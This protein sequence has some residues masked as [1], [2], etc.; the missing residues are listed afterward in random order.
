[1]RLYDLEVRVRELTDALSLSVDAETGEIAEG[2]IAELEAALKERD[3]RVLDIACYYRE[4]M[5][6]A[7]AVKAEA[8]RLRARMQ[9]LTN[10]ADRLKD[11]IAGALQP[12]ETRSDARVRLSWRKTKSVVVSTVPE[13]LPAEFQRTKVEADKVALRKALD[14]GATIEGAYIA[15]DASLQI[16]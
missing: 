3:E 7:G 5:A 8:E 9:V 1:M 13:L 2:A 16:R 6:E 4:V 10:R 12:G 14:G 11:L 15:E